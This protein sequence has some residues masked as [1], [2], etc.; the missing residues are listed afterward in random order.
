MVVAYHFDWLPGGFFGVDVFFVL[1]GYLITTVLC[2]EWTSAESIDLRKFYTRRLLRLTPALY[3][4]VLVAFVL[5]ETVAGEHLLHPRWAIVTLLYASNLLTA[6]GG[7]YPLGFVSHC[8]S[9][10]LEE[11]FYLLWPFALRT[12]LRRGV[13][14]RTLL[15]VMVVL[16]LASTLWRL[17]LAA[18]LAD[19]PDGWLRVYFG[20]DTRADL[21][22]IGCALALLEH[23]R[24][25]ALALS[26]AWQAVA[27]VAGIA[28]L[29]VA[30][31]TPS[32]EDAVASPASFTIAAL[33]ALLLIVGTKDRAATPV[34]R[35]FEL[36]ARRLARAALVQP[37]PL[38]RARP[39]GRRERPR[40]HAGPL[41]AREVHAAVRPRCSVLLSRRAAVPPAEGPARRGSGRAGGR[42]PAAGRRPVTSRQATGDGRGVAYVHPAG[43]ARAPCPGPGAGRQHGGSRR[44]LACEGVP[45]ILRRGDREL[46]RRGHAS[47]AV[48]GSDPPPVSPRRAHRVYSADHLAGADELR[49]WRLRP[50]PDLRG[51]SRALRRAPVCHELP[52]RNPVRAARQRAPVRWRLSPRHVLRSGGHLPRLQL[53]RGRLSPVRQ[54]RPRAALLR[55]VPRCHAVLH[56]HWRD[57]RLHGALSS[58]RVVARPKLRPR[59]RPPSGPSVAAARAGARPGRRRARPARG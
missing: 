8:W 18:A 11:Q 47:A 6:F 52:V 14:V 55:C 5:A 7:V 36:R 28:L 16:A 32:I 21:L 30:A 23:D 41:V 24:P 46:R 49:V 12:A 3:V 40:R 15:V 50:R 17:H 44:V 29:G 33:G 10:G 20:P 38:A 45:P 59:P 2:R 42:D 39:D 35:F 48:P 22:A 53:H 26:A 19:D 57:L 56:R 1:S 27:A 9:L 25:A 54:V 13:R 43:L 58:G 31:S 34:T 51:R 4:F 37:L